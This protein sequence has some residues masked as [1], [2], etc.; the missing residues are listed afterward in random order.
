MKTRNFFFLLMALPL[1]LVACNKKSDDQS[2]T[3]K[4]EEYDVRVEAKYLLAEYWGDEFKTTT[5]LSSP[6]T[7][8]R[9]TSAV[10]H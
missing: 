3:S 7:S 8:L 1:M 2:N 4:P 9:W 6:R 10:G 5:R